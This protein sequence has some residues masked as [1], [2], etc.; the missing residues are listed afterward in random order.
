MKLEELQIALRERL[1]QPLPGEEAYQHMI[2]KSIEGVRLK[3]ELN[4]QTKKGGVMILLYEEEQTIKFPLIQRPTYKGVHSGQISFPGGKI[5]DKDPDTIYTA[6]R[7]THEEI[8][9]PG[10]QVEVIGSLSEYFVGASNNL[11]LPVIGM[12]NSRPAFIPDQHE[13]SEIVEATIP[14]LLDDA[15]VKHKVLEVGENRFK[16]NTPYFDIKGKVVWGATAVM[17][18]EFKHI[19]KEI[20]A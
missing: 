5:E 2:P 9:V 6:I 14:E 11:V 7:E 13:V 3:F 17:L 4:A 1:N 18:S 12:T 19:L 15:I 10:E 20:Y 8:G 16:L